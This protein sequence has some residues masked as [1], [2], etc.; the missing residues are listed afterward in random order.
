MTIE[1][2]ADLHCHTS[3]SDGSDTPE[4]L[5]QRAFESGLSGLSITDHDTTAAYPAALDVAR[6]KN[7]LLLSGIE[8]SAAHR[9]E[10]V[11]ILG[12]AFNLQSR[13]IADL[14]EK[15]KRRRQE[16][17]SGILARL[18]TLGIV[19]EPEELGSALFEGSLGRPHI[20]HILLKRGIVSTIQEAF[21]RYLAEGKPAYDPGVPI[22]VE[23]TIKVIHQGKGKAVLAHPHLLK[24]STTIR[25]MLQMPFDGL[26]CYYARFTS[27]QEKKWVDLAR[28]RKWLITGGSDYHGTTK[29]Y[30]FLGSS[31]VG[32]E[33]FDLLYTHFLCANGLDN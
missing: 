27:G 24:R 1:F 23:E 29:P 19:I 6:S 2:R 21:E 30:S 5:V 14:C 31:W 12:Y 11:H 33:T 4:Q 3:F 15:H 20:A 8:F 26:E 13:E 9:G 16:R 22:S 10:P 18:R 25:A 7:I 28:Q 17:N 32:K